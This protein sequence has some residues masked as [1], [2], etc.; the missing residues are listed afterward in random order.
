[1]T[2]NWSRRSFLKSSVSFAS[3]FCALQS[4]FQNG[5]IA[6]S[7]ADVRP[8]YGSLVSDPQG[9]L[10]LPPGFSYRIISRGGEKMVDGY[11]TPAKPD[12]MA[13]FEGPDGLTLLVIN[14]ELT[15]IQD[16][17][18]FGDDDSLL[19]AEHR[20]LIY[21]PG[22]IAHHG[23][24][25]TLVYDTKRQ[26]TVRQFL[27]LAGT[28]RNCAGGPTPWNS[29]ITCEETVDLQGEILDYCT[30]KGYS[31]CIDHGFNFEVPA[32][33]EPRLE[34]AVPLKDMGRFNHEAVAVDPRT[35]I[36]YQTEDR[37][38]GLIYRFLPNVPGKLVE[39]GRLQ[40]LCVADAKPLD[41]RNWSKQ[42][43]HVGEPRQVEWIDMENVLAPED[44]LRKRGFEAG[45]AKFARGEGMWYS[46]EQ[47]FF[48]CTSGG[49][50][51]TG[52]IWRLV[53]GVDGAPDSLELFIEP[54]DSALL[55]AADNLTVSPWGDLFVCE[56]R[57]GEVVRVVG[58]TME[59][60]LYTFAA[61]HANTEFAGVTFSPDGSTMFVNLQH[62]DLTIA[63]TGP[64][65][66]PVG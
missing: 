55:E 23:G 54:N 48:S 3:G 15:P 49:S 44:D 12:G 1:M 28:C 51:K 5:A 21:D 37:D 4:A 63:I 11:I 43:V 24:T 57:N 45:A 64:W 25:T 38:N 56:D 59:G 42:R 10:D 14:H 22:P 31:C 47:I 29:W 58:V 35:G 33:A 46:E 16:P 52:Q 30:G 62:A 61:N 32:R 18:P 50:N 13:T 53:P 17:G 34:A 7:S 9:I 19:Q 39:G 27:S 66:S 8:K 2:S 41:T 26:Q 40:A 60:S 36:V 20:G 65:T 6:H